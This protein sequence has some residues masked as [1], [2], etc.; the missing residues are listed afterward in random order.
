[1]NRWAI[2]IGL[3]A[4]VCVTA[5][6]VSQCSGPSAVVDG[7]P[8][9][10]APEQPGQPYRV[11]ASIRNTGPGHGEVEVTFSLRDTATGQIYQQIE[12]AQLEPHS[13]IRLAV[14]MPAAPGNYAPSVQVKYPPG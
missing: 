7:Q 5:L 2:L 4:V 9:V 10:V 8:V 11:E 13:L 1:M 14:E 12:H 3:V 6:W